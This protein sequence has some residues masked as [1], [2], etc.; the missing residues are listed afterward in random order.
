L[1]DDGRFV[2]A[3]SIHPLRAF[4]TRRVQDAIMARW[5]DAALVALLVL[6]ASCADGSRTAFSNALRDP[7]GRAP[8]AGDPVVLVALDGVRWQ[9]VFDGTDRKWWK[10]PRSTAVEIAPH[11]HALAHD[12]GAAV[13]APGRG[14]IAATGPHFVSLPGYTEMLTGRAPLS[15][16]DND[17]DPV[18]I[19]TLLDE[20][21][22]AGARVAAF[23][24]WERVE[25]AATSRP[26][27]FFVS[28]GQSEPMDP[29]PGHG[30]YRPDRATAELALAYLE[31]QRPD[32]LFLGLGDPDEHAHHGDY[33]G[34]LAAIRRADDVLG[35][36]E[37]TLARLGE[38]GA[39]THVVVTADHGRSADFKDHGGFAPESARVWLVAS[40]P[41]IEARGWIASPRDRSLADV[42]PTIRVVLGLR[43]DRSAFA[44]RAIDELFVPL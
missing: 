11:L 16:R 1:R 34:Y 43:A 29:A 20:A 19:P 32:V 17:C 38:R 2:F 13:G 42:V 30:R 6:G 26:G 31:E 15:C 35:R 23:A 40:G 21:H 36:L 44:G 9:E 27:A 10:G 18:T 25:R 33:A 4:V 7:H 39:R 24:S 22:A 3:Q 14:F 5:M 12:R 8:W 41:R 28:C 37:A